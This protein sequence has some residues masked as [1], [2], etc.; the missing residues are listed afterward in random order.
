MIRQFFSPEN[1]WSQLADVLMVVYIFEEKGVHAMSSEGD[2]E[3]FALKEVESYAE[4]C[5]F[6][7]RELDTDVTKDLKPVN[8][9]AMSIF[10]NFVR[11]KIYITNG[12]I[13]TITTKRTCG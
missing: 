12:V 8:Q 1:P 6:G 5:I 3:C 2:A 9:L 4:E 11:N 13:S 7:K 10:R